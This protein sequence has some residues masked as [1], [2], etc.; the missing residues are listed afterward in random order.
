MEKKQW[1]ML[2]LSLTSLS[3]FAG[4]PSFTQVDTNSDGVIT[5][6]EFQAYIDPTQNKKM[7]GSSVES[8]EQVQD[9]QGA[10]H[11]SSSG[12]GA[13]S[14]DAV[15]DPRGFDG[16]GDLSDPRLSDPTRPPS[17]DR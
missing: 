12:P 4:P 6:S 3:V 9:P 15:P 10:M 1:I 2:G 8:A 17:I 16:S 5:K 11:R 13:S 14:S 7:R